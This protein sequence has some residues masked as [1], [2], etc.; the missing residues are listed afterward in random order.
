MSCVD[1]CG[2]CTLLLCKRI[3]SELKMTHLPPTV[4]PLLLKPYANC[5]Q[6]GQQL[7]HMNEKFCYSEEEKQVKL[8]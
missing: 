1:I 7:Q 3:L 5:Y 2:H 8:A 6:K 4:L